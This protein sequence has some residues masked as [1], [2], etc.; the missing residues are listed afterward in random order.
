MIVVLGCRSNSDRN[1]GSRYGS[2]PFL[3]NGMLRSL[4]RIATRPTSPAKSRA[5]RARD[6]SGW[7]RR[8]PPWRSTNSLWIENSPMPEKTPGKVSSTRRM[9]SAAYMSAGLKPVII[10]SSR[11]CW[12]GRERPVRHRDEGVGEG[13]VVEGSVGLEVIGG[14]EVPR[15]PVVPLLLERNAEEGGAADP[16]SPS[17]GRSRRRACLPG[18][19]WS[20]GNASRCT[21][22]RRT[23]GSVRTPEQRPP[24]SGRPRQDE[25]SVVASQTLRPG[26]GRD[27]GC[28]SSNIVDVKDE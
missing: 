19:S 10:G 5:G 16:Y 14:R 15:V 17:S 18:R 3:G 8:P 4:C 9:W 24:G 2:C 25:A 6:W 11:A 12:S 13:I 1:W 23:P 22:R 20:G 26:W 27:G 28:R 7:P 21:W